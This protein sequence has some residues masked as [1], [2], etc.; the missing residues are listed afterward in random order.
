MNNFAANLLFAAVWA[1]FSGGF[2]WLSMT[3]GFVLGYGILWLLQPLTGVKS[4]YFKRVYFWLKLLV[5][6]FYEL[7]VSSVAVIYDII[8]PTLLA[9]PAIIDMP[10]DVKSDTGIL[11]VTNLISL[12]PGTLSIDVS[13]DRKTLRIH[14]M[15][16]DDPDAVCHELKSGM[17]K[18][19]IDAMED[20]PA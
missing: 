3:F 8:T 11:L 7:F 19:V 18:W 6:F 10:L 5:M 1:I 13:P 2:S 15:F 16:A 4:S 14:A 9:R 20:H 17:E 12:T